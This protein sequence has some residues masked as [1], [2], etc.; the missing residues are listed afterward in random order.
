MTAGGGGGAISALGETLA[1]GQGRAALIS[2][3]LK[4]PGREGGEKRA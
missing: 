2:L 1:M 4:L 3:P